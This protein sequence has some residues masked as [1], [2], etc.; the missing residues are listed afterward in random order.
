MAGWRQDHPNALCAVPGKLIMP[1]PIVIGVDVGATKILVGAV[2]RTG[3]VLASRRSQIN[4]KTQE[5]TLE[6]IEIAIHDFLQYW[7][8][9]RLLAIGAGV[10][11]QTDPQAGAWLE[12]MNLPIADPVSLG[13]RLREQY[14]VPIALDNDVHAATLAEMRWGIGTE[15]MDFIYL[16]VG[17]GIAAGL[18]FNGQLV[19]GT[20]NYAGEFGHMLV[21]PDGPLCPCGRRGCVE[22]IAS[23][24]GMLARAQELLADFPDST[25]HTQAESLTAHSIFAAADAGD[26]LAIKIS[27]AAV[28]AL[29]DAL[30]NLVN[31]LNPEWIV[32]GGGTLSDGW[33][34]ER[35]RHHVETKPLLMTR[36]SL[37]GILPSRLDPNQVGLLGGAC[38]AWDL[39]VKE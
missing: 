23:G 20:G 30:V 19:R 5:T 35:V 4:A 12:A 13:E 27:S 7:D 31:L 3:Q 14:G 8:G 29:S 24:G 38:L 15:S 39:G 16:N 26:P 37:K 28:R 22:P 34:I 6:S 2:T 21:Q 36:K 17:T 25:L 11:G 18:V 32:Y 33:L 10:V 1:E 9:P